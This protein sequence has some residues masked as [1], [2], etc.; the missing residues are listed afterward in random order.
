MPLAAGTRIGPYEI[1]APLGKGGMG[2]VYRARDPRL[3]R[4]VAI[5]VLPQESAA[6]ADRLRRFEQE[7]HAVAALNH[8]NVLAIYDVGVHDGVPYLVCELL[9]GR[10]LRQRLAEGPLPVAEAM[11]L[12]RQTAAG[13]E[14]AHRAGVVHR[15]LK[16]ENLLVTDD[17]RVKILDFGLAKLHA[18]VAASS[19]A[20]T[21]SRPGHVLGTVGYMAPEQVLGKPVDARADVFAAGCVLYEMLSSRAPFA[22]DTPIATLRAITD[23]PADLRSLPV[24]ARGIVS[25]CLAKR[26]E[27]R[28]PSGCELAAALAQV[29]RDS[30]HPGNAGHPRWLGARP[31]FVIAL[32]AVLAAAVLLGPFRRSQRS[33]TT[34]AGGSISLAVLPFDTLGGE[35]KAYLSDGITEVLTTDLSRASGV[36]VVASSAAFRTSRHAPDPRAAARELGVTRVVTG[37]VQHT[38]DR[39]RVSARL[40]DGSN[41]ASLW[42]DRFDYDARDVFALQDSVS[43]RIADALRVEL[44]A[45]ASPVRSGSAVDPAA[46]DLYLRGLHARRNHLQD[47]GPAIAL[48]EQAVAK[49]PDFAPA[50]AALGSAWAQQFFYEDA[51]PESER[52]AEAA[53]DRALALDPTLADA[54]ASR[55]QLR[56]TLQNGFPHE[57][58]VTDLRRA[59][60][61]DPSSE[62]AHRELGKIYVHV[63]LLERSIEEN[64]AALRLDPG[65]TN[66]AIRIIRARLYARQCAQ[67]FAAAERLPTYREDRALALACLGRLPEALALMEAPA[68][69]NPNDHESG[70]L[71]LLL[72]LAGRRQQ[73]EAGLAQLRSSAANEIGLSHLHHRQYTI[74]STY[75]VLGQGDRAMIWLQKA[76]DEG[77][78]CYP[79]FSR[80]PNLASLQQRQDF[81][82]L[83]QR[84]R[85]SWE[86]WSRALG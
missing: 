12:A 2:V 47:L 20:L 76:A 13:L 71:P 74:G 61:L 49:A 19:E 33:T 54:Y 73:A 52:K 24:S 11:E 84:L 31:A 10:T 21:E 7:A 60:A 66:A 82:A 59:I 30:S 67:A 3:S 78:P 63:G 62:H 44:R 29:G 38:G 9:R 56:W 16:P 48:L 6:S 22:R 57:E 1:V 14:A 64:D 77:L 80:D 69:D 5:K 68:P 86:R 65:D 55:G 26:P 23:D 36:M 35:D 27:G 53:I 4:E 18:D 41:G 70:V 51:K 58:A 79:L 32:L 85:A 15:D 81:R 43:R 75:A 39:V 34:A 8:P 72:A 17:G 25:R 28:F 40:V 37:S 42:A 46:Y 45:T 50:Y 83:L